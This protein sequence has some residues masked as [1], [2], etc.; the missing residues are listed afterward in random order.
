VTVTTIPV[1]FDPFSEE[2]FKDPYELY[3]RLHDEVSVYYS[4]RT[5]SLCC[6]ASPTC[7]PRTE[8]VKPS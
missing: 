1:E 7:W 2:F 5:G 3:R 6:R 8:T 4:E